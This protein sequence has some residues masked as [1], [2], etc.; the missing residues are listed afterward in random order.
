[1]DLGQWI[2]VGFSIFLGAWYVIASVINRRRGVATFQWLRT[3]LE[4]YGKVSAAKWIGTAASGARL[5]IEGAKAPFRRIEAVFLLDS[6]EIL[7]LWLFNLL[8][9]KSDE[10]LLK[11]TLRRVPTHQM[12]VA[13]P[14]KLNLEKLSTE[15]GGSESLH[16]SQ[17]AG[18][19]FAEWGKIAPGA[20]RIS[21]DFFSK[22]GADIIS[23]SLRRAVPHLIVKVR[24]SGIRST[25]AD[26]FLQALATW[27]DNLQRGLPDE[28][29]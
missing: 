25:P 1:V 17:I 29:Q 21:E 18:L 9:R 10:L 19:S 27:I 16:Q 5:A 6:R 20:E 12:E 7:P 26:E 24:L 3:G 11:T 23:L 15:I 2:I 22:Y 4:K 14:G 28:D 13:H 8:R